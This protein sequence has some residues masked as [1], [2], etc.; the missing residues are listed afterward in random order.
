MKRLRWI[1]LMTI[2]LMLAA[3]AHQ[4]SGVAPNPI[5]PA[6]DFALTDENGQPFKLSDLRGK[7][8]LLA[9]GYT[10]CPDVC[11]LTLSHLRD[12]KK[13]VDPNGDKVQVVFTTI[14]PERD[15]TD[16]MQKYVSHFDQQF[17]QKFKGLSGTPQEIAQAAKAYNVKYEKKDVKPDGSYT[18]GHTAEVYLIDPQFNWRMTFP[19]GV[20]AEEIAGDVQYLMQNPEAK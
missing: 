9:Y 5:G 12:V 17:A 3:C 13:T 20:K 1:A 7:W 4:F 18:M 15:T 11:P 16:I 2:G 14:D 6:P 8:I 10:H 19:F